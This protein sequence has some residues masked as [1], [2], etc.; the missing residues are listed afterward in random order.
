MPRPYSFALL[1]LLAALL[2]AACARPAPL[3]EAPTTQVL[4]FSIYP[5]LEVPARDV[6]SVVTV[7]PPTSECEDH[8][9]DCSLFPGGFEFCHREGGY[10]CFNHYPT[11]TSVTITALGTRPLEWVTECKGNTTRACTFVMDA[12]KSVVLYFH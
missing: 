12:S 8:P 1:F 11:G 9:S 3:G 6:G 2:L 5:D 7:D 4:S 10:Q